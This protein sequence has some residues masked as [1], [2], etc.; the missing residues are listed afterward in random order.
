MIKLNSSVRAVFLG[1][2]A[3][4]LGACATTQETPAPATETQ[5]VR[6]AQPMG[7]PEPTLSYSSE[8][9][10]YNV[11]RG[12]HLWGIASKPAIYGN[13]YQWP[14]IYKA[15]SG[16][17]QDADLIYPGQVFTIE[18]DL[19]RSDVDAAVRH[20]K[21]RGAWSIGAIEDSDKRYLS[22]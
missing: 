9:S 10:T 18:T 3:L 5:P 4:S 7:S 14:L 13:P 12:D 8:T 16:K 19:S 15:N 2:A 21:S 22:R 20:A 6:E 11:V 1:V 17:I